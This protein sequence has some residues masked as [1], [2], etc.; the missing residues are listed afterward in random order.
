MSSV[1]DTMVPAEDRVPLVEPKI[2]L[3]VEN[4]Q[5][6]AKVS[7]GVSEWTIPVLTPEESERMLREEPRIPME[8]VLRELREEF[9][10]FDD[11]CDDDLQADVP[12]LIVLRRKD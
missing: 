3:T 11:N 8:Q 4:G 1:N 10:D 9:G 2:R 6:V 12:Q 5:R 7:D